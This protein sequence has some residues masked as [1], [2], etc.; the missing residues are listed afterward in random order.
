MHFA[1]RGDEYLRDGGKLGAKDTFYAFIEHNQ[2]LFNTQEACL[3][4]LGESG[5]WSHIQPDQGMFGSPARDEGIHDVPLYRELCQRNQRLPNLTALNLFIVEEMFK[6]SDSTGCVFEYVIDATLKHTDGICTGVIDHVIRLTAQFMRACQMAYPNAAV[7]VS[8]RNEWDAHNE[9]RTTLEQVNN[10]AERWYR[11]KHK[12]WR[13]ERETPKAPR[14]V[15]AFESPGADWEAEQWP[16][17]FLI[18]DH[19]GRDLFRYDCGPEAGR[20]K[21][22]ALHPERSGNLHKRDR[23]FEVTPEWMSDVRRD[24]RGQPVGFTESMYFVSK[25][26]T[27]GWYRNADRWNDDL[28][29]QMAFYAGCEA[30]WGPDLWYVHD[31]IGVMCDPYW[32]PGT[33][34]EARL[35]EYFGGLVPAPAPPPVEHWAVPPVLRILEMGYM[36]ILGRAPDPT[37]SAHYGGKLFHFEMTEADFRAAL[38]R[39]YVISGAR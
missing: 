29:D 15:T 10:W 35:A 12:D 2:K 25:P 19:G 22:G 17:G 11:W 3:R 14:P 39:D 9:T 5:G 21:L 38:L 18:V 24:S 13:N 6:A 26:G 23:W 33:D 4:V 36:E 30:P 37:G 32:N 28:D 34:W 16:E 31:D 20:F 7:F 27:E 1:G 8:A